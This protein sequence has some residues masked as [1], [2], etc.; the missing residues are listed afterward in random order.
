MSY[1]QSN[2][3]HSPFPLEFKAYRLVLKWI[4]HL[5]NCFVL[6]L[7]L[8]AILRLLAWGINTQLNVSIVVGASKWEVTGIPY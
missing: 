7:D 8:F 1:M 6:Q 2:N 5:N 4:I 3:I